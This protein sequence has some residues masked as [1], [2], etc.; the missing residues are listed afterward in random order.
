MGTPF[1]EPTRRAT[2]HLADR[3]DLLP[4]R[5]TCRQLPWERAGRPTLRPRGGLWGV[6]VGF[7]ASCSPR[8][9]KGLA[10]GKPL[11][12]ARGTWKVCKNGPSN[13][14]PFRNVRWAKGNGDS[15]R[16]PAVLLPGSSAAVGVDES[17]G[18][19]VPGSGLSGP[20]PLRGRTLSSPGSR[21]TLPL[22]EDP[23]GAKRGMRSGDSAG[24]SRSIRI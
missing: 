20:L 3:P 17:P 6:P 1:V 10:D 7:L 24:R 15:A 5:C 12:R 11:F 19:P 13:A 23:S 14:L 2:C 4:A 21:E 18:P 22:S 9:S 8:T 16:T